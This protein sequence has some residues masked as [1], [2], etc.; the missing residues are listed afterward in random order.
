MAMAS[1]RA[2]IYCGINTYV[3]KIS[4]LFYLW[5]YYNKNLIS[6]PRYNSSKYSYKIIKEDFDTKLCL[7]RYP[8]VNFLNIMNVT[9]VLQDSLVNL[10]SLNTVLYWSKA[11][12]AMVNTVVKEIAL[13]FAWQDQDIEFI[14]K[15]TTKNLPNMPKGV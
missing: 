11:V 1:R 4:I 6:P 12:E 7:R 2:K 10:K 9:N 5:Y 13:K 8:E 15:E 3:K 14:N